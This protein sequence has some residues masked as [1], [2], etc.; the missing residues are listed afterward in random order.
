VLTQTSGLDAYNAYNVIECLVTLARD[1]NRT[2]VF[3]IHQPRSNIV[4]LFDQLI[5]LAEGK[6]VY[7]GPFSRCQDYFN[8]I[9]HPCP[10]GFNIGDYLVDLTM[11]ASREAPETEILEE[12]REGES[13]AVQRPGRQRRDSVR[14]WQEHQLYDPHPRTQESSDGEIDEFRTT[15]Q[16]ASV[17]V[18]EQSAPTANAADA[19][20]ARQ[21]SEQLHA[22]EHLA[23]LMYSYSNSAICTAVLDEIESAV[24]VDEG[25]EVLPEEVPK[26]KR[27]GW[28]SQFVILSG[29]TFKNLYRNPMLMLTHYSIA[30]LMARKPLCPNVTDVVM[31]GY[32]YFG[33]SDDIEAF[34][35]RM[36]LFFFI[37][38][39]FGFS[40]LTSLNIFASER[41]LF[42]R[43]RANGYYS[44]FIYFLSKVPLHG[45]SLTVGAI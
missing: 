4:A 21:Q 42:V 16:W 26:S 30:I 40:T 12:G 27:I 24:V 18:E 25:E 22:A 28:A 15:Q 34:Q 37:L 2:V 39:L 32:L 31:C 35:N 20:R 3:T 36:G 33:I 9:G 44:P 38:A 13:T 14:E 7:S 5:L 11:H 17:V 29:R 8:S 41:I 23:M 6:M 43:E 10:P 1:F 45:S 19:K